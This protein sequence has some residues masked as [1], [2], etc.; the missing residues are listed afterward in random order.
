MTQ[1]TQNVEQRVESAADRSKFNGPGEATSSSPNWQIEAERLAGLVKNLQQEC[2]MLRQ[3]LA[4][5]EAE[6]DLYLQAVYANARAT[7]H[8]E[9]IDIPE[10][11]AASAGPV[12][13]LE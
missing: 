1:P 3:S 11:E 2:A 10:L 12:E 7:L 9:E 8:F 13:P 5:V 6:R 4:K